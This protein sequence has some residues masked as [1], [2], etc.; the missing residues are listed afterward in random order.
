MIIKILPIMVI[1]FLCDLRFAALTNNKAR[2]VDSVYI[3]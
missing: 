1:P 3:Y 2:G